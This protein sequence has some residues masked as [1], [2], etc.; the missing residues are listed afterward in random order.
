MK[1]SNEEVEVILSA[2]IDAAAYQSEME[3]SSYEAE[4]ADAKK[5]KAMYKEIWLKLGMGRLR[6]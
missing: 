6:A 5:R 1:I 3:K 2:L 4:V